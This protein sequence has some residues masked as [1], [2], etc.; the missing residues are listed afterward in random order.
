M[1]QKMSDQHK[2]K[3]LEKSELSDISKITDIKPKKTI[4]QVA[5]MQK[6]KTLRHKDNGFITLHHISS[7]RTGIIKDEGGPTKY[8]KSDSSNTLWDNN[9][10][11]NLPMDSKTKTIQNK[12]RIITNKREAEQKRMN[13]LV[14]ALKN[15]DQTK[16]S[17]VSKMSTLEGSSYKVPVGNISMFDSKD[18]DKL[19]EKTAGE[20][21][22]ENNINKKNQKDDSWRD[23]GKSITTK[24]VVSEFFDNLMQKKD[25]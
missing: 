25:E 12:E 1:L 16:A 17:A 23:E 19:P 11:E 6:A 18:F 5:E 20:K 3:F 14:E 13:D 24:E 8:I 10:I 7:A 21:I 4:E 9:K 2:I 22:T 15:T